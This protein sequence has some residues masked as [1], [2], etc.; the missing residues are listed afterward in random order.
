M[1]RLMVYRITLINKLKNKTK[2]TTLRTV[3][4]F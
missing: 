1:K 3:Q 4:K 2:N